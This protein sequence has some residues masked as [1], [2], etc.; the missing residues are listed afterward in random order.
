VYSTLYI[1]NPELMIE[2]MTGGSAMIMAPS[3]DR[4]LKALK[5]FCR[6]LESLKSGQPHTESALH[7]A[8]GKECFEILQD[9]NI[10][11]PYGLDGAIALGVTQV[12][13]M[14]AGIPLQYSN[15]SNLEPDDLVIIQAPIATTT[16][17]PS[18]TR[19]G[20][21]VR[22]FLRQSLMKNPWAMASGAYVDH[23]FGTF[24]SDDKL[25]LYDMGY[26]MYD[27]HDDQASQ[28]GVRLQH[29]LERI[30]SRGAAPVVLGGDHAQAFYS[31][32]ALAKRYRKVGI[33]HIDAHTDLYQ[34]SRSR[35]RLLNHANVMCHVAHMA[36]VDSIWQVGIRDLHHEQGNGLDPLVMGKLKCL[37]AFE[38]AQLG[39]ARLLESFDKSIPWFISFD[40][41]ALEFSDR[42][43]TATPVLGG[44]SYYPL[45]AFFSSFIKAAAVV[46]MEVVEV[47]DSAQ[48]AHGPAAI[49]ARLISR[50][51][52]HC[53]RE[54]NMT[55]SAQRF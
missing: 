52:F 44:L 53:R 8:L 18:V 13:S 22:A 28:V 6:K 41:D 42:P 26:V 5:A 10:I 21:W 16:L 35:S 32:A 49:A 40:V 1:V 34:V 51:I 30:Y 43:E 20:N 19:G 2:D 33:L 31:I 54:Q 15:L 39:Y 36:H 46:G 12:C 11:L 23:D 3:M 9:L 37:S 45:L 25:N 27:P 4:G 7:G 47:G 55:S 50:Y 14:P 29:V 24:I 38:I 17:A 48:S